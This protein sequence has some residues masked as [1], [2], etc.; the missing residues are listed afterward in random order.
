MSIPSNELICEIGEYLGFPM[1]EKR[2]KSKTY[3][4][5]GNR[6]GEDEHGDDYFEGSVIPY[7]GIRLLVFKNV[8]CYGI[9]SQ[10]TLNL[11]TL[12]PTRNSPIQK[13]L[14]NELKQKIRS[15][16]VQPYGS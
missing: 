13:E 5:P 2:D 7:N 8:G 16:N 6:D 15:K 3:S 12:R 10:Y 9:N 1:W 14:S 11:S 4:F